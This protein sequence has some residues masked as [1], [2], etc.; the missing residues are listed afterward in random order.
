M[1]KLRISRQL[2]YNQNIAREMYHGNINLI[3]TAKVTISSY[4]R[5][6]FISVIVIHSRD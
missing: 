5:A 3:G 1:W 2:S 4:F 6:N